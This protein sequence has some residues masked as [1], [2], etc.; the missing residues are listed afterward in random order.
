[1][2]ETMS[3][4]SPSRRE[5]ERLAAVCK[6]TKR[7]NLDVNMGP[8]NDEAYFSASSQATL[9]A[10]KITTKLPWISRPWSFSRSSFSLVGIISL[11]NVINLIAFISLIDLVNLIAFINL[12]DIISLI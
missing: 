10:S 12:I 5:N 11:V 1:M 8:E 6:A 9:F 3:W 2:H 7:G 4:Q